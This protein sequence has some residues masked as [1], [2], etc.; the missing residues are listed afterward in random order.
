MRISRGFSGQSP[1]R[2]LRSPEG[3]SAIR[4]LALKGAVHF[5]GIV[6]SGTRGGVLIAPQL[7]ASLQAATLILPAMQSKLIDVINMLQ[8]VLTHRSPSSFQRHS[9]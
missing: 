7:R 9:G 6:R 5:W 4:C 2:G 3:G 8:A 1:M